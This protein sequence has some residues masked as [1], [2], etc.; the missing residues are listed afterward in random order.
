[1]REPTG[2]EDQTLEEVLAAFLY[3]SENMFGEI[4]FDAQ[5]EL[6]KRT[7]PPVWAKRHPLPDLAKEWHK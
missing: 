7:P 2:F 4:V 3:T 5:R 6:Y 1:M